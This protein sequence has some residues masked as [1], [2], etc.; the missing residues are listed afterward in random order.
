MLFTI[1]ENIYQLS[2]NDQNFYQNGRELVKIYLKKT[3]FNIL[4]VIENILKE[5]REVKFITTYRE[6]MM[7]EIR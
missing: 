6:S 4:S 7:M 2:V 1:G 3:Y 5:G